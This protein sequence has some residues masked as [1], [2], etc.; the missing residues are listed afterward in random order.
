M[1]VFNSKRWMGVIPV[2]CAVSGLLFSACNSEDEQPIGEI[3]K[4]NQAKKC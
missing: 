2:L 3:Q 1:E 4:V